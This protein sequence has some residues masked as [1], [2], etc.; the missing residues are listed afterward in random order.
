MNPADG[1]SCPEGAVN[2]NVSPD[3]RINESV[4]GLKDSF[5]EKDMAVTIVGEARKFIVKGLPSFRDLKFL[6]KLETIARYQNE[7]SIGN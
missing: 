3:G 5:P 7:L 1:R 6:L 2:L 4:M